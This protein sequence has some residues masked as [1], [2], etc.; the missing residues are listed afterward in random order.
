MVAMLVTGF[1]AGRGSPARASFG[2]ATRRNSKV[3]Y[4]DNKAATDSPRAIASGQ[5]PSG[6]IGGTASLTL[7]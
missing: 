6:L 2:R 7:R 5:L 4:A 1:A 3:P